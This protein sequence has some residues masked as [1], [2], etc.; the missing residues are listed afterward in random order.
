MSALSQ[1]AMETSFSTNINDFDEGGEGREFSV[2]E[3]KFELIKIIPSKN[4]RRFNSGKE[5][6]DF[7]EEIK[8]VIN[9]NRNYN[10]T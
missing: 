5:L 7:L 6:Y 3:P 8:V 4:P 1:E 2:G 10:M 9:S